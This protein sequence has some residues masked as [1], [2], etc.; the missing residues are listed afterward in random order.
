MMWPDSNNILVYFKV[1]FK[2]TNHAI[3][4]YLQKKI[5]NTL[6]IWNTFIIKYSFCNISFNFFLIFDDAICTAAHKWTVFSCLVTL[7]WICQITNDSRQYK[8]CTW[9]ISLNSEIWSFQ[10]WFSENVTMVS[11]SSFSSK[12]FIKFWW[13]YPAKFMTCPTLVA[14]LYT[15]NNFWQF[16]KCHRVPENSTTI[17]W[18]NLFLY[19]PA[20]FNSKNIRQAQIKRSELV[21]P[22]QNGLKC[23]FFQKNTTLIGLKSLTTFNY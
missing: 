1:K 20:Q 2:W 3:Y 19:S 14:I 5:C 10:V 21:M 12:I 8:W 9:L 15:K 11:I 7:A 22:C 17:W 4:M 13:S 18:R 23:S 6:Y 16:L